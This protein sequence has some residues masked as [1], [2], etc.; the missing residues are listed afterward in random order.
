MR[1]NYSR[2]NPDLLLGVQISVKESVSCCG[3]CYVPHSRISTDVHSLT[4]YPKR[5]SMCRIMSGNVPKRTFLTAVLGAEVS[6][7]QKYDSSLNS[8]LSSMILSQEILFITV[9]LLD[10]ACPHKITQTS[11][12]RGQEGS[13]G[14]NRRYDNQ[15]QLTLERSSPSQNHQKLPRAQS[16]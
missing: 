7:D 3:C 10:R 13:L 4:E 15:V 5:N 11:L 9:T 2:E 16:R 12:P 8:T 14:S 1:Q 6:H